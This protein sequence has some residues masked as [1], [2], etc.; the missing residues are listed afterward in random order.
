M[1]NGVGSL[2]ATGEVTETVATY[3]VQTEAGMGNDALFN[4]VINNGGVF[5]FRSNIVAEAQTH[6]A[7]GANRTEGQTKLLVGD[8]VAL[9]GDGV[10]EI[11]A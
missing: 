6:D 5:L 11:V 2:I 9:N 10:V 1:P 8:L 4:H 7:G 3:Q